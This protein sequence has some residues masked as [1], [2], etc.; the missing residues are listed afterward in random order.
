MT[1]HPR[2]GSPGGAPRALVAERGKGSTEALF[3]LVQPT[4]ARVGHRALRAG[5]AGGRPHPLHD[6]GLHVAAGEVNAEDLSVAA[7]ERL[8]SLASFHLLRAGGLR[9]P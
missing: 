3:H 9:D 5:R 7:P 1:R 6:R 2:R 4:L 8:D